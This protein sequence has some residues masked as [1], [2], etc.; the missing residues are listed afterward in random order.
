MIERTGPPRHFWGWV[1]EVVV[2]FIAVTVLAAIG[3]LIWALHW[4]DVHVVVDRADC[5][6]VVFVGDGRNWKYAPDDCR[7]FHVGERWLIQVNDFG[8]MRPNKKE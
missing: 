6:S 2:L 3:G 5:S 8:F 4:R 7:T 1:A